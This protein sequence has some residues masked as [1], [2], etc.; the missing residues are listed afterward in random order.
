MLSRIPLLRHIFG[1]NTVARFVAV[2]PGVKRLGITF[3]ALLGFVLSMFSG[4]ASVAAQDI[5]YDMTSYGY[6]SDNDDIGLMLIHIEPDDP[7]LAA[8]FVSPV[9]AEE[10]LQ[11]IGILD[12]YWWAEGLERGYRNQVEGADEYMVFEGDLNFYDGWEFGYVMLLSV[13]QEIFLLAGYQADANDLFDL[14]EET[15]DAE[16]V[17][18]S[19]NDFTRVNLDDEELGSSNNQGS[20]SSSGDVLCYEDRNLRSL[21]FDDDG[22]ITVDELEEFA[23]DPAVDDV[24]DLLEDDG[25]DGIEYENC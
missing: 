21:D 12:E 3:F 9:Y 24:I 4:L 1:R 15:I 18:R 10:F 17:P 11:T 14:A 16:A 7:R 5:D 25:Y 19:F 13:D 2:R 20:N 6:F 8:E 23:G 22:V